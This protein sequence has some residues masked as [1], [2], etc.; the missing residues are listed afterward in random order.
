M[1]HHFDLR[2]LDAQVSNARARTSTS[3]RTCRTCAL[4]RPKQVLEHMQQ[5]CLVVG[6]R[7]ILNTART[8][9]RV[10]REETTAVASNTLYLALRLG[11]SIGCGQWV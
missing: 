3:R 9:C 2:G 5:C 8:A 10:V 11:V 7:N 1:A 6:K 4:I